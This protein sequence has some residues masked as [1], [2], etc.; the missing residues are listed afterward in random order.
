[1]V[2]KENQT[3]GLI[4]SAPKSEGQLPFWGVAHANPRN[5]VLLPKCK[6]IFGASAEFAPLGPPTTADLCPVYSPCRYPE[7][8]S[9]AELQQPQRSY[10]N[11]S[12]TA[13]QGASPNAC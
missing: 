11:G 6:T 12:V 4:L 8:E 3:D 2:I 7:R 9:G 1:M 5:R 10:G 13:H